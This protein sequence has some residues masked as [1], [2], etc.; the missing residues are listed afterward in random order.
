[1][2]K[3]SANIQIGEEQFTDLKI[4]FHPLRMVA[5]KNGENLKIE[6]LFDG[7]KCTL[8]M[9]GDITGTETKDCEMDSTR[10]IIDYDG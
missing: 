2:A 5:T 7:E 8:A 10:Y 1:M 4:M 9:V 6:Q 3:L